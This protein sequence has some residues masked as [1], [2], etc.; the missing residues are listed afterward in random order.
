MNILKKYDYI[1]KYILF[2]LIAT[3]I[4]TIIN[5]IIPLNK[6][7]N[8]IITFIYMLIYSFILGIKK[9]LKSNEKAYLEGLKLGIIETLI[10]YSLSIITL[11]FR[12]SIKRILYY[13]IIIT[14]TTLGSIIGINKKRS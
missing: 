1:F 2:I 14:I 11:D 5:I 3:I 4:T 12:I 13:L 8:Q 10:L 9:G 7:T 6:N